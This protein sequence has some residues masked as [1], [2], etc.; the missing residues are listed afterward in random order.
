MK[1]T[2][3]TFYDYLKFELLVKNTNH[4]SYY[5]WGESFLETLLYTSE[6]RRAVIPKDEILWRSQLGKSESRKVHW[7]EGVYDDTSPLPHYAERMKPRFGMA[8][9]GRINPK[10]ISYLY[11]STDQ[12][13]AMAECRPW[14]QAPIS[15]GRFITTKELSIVDFS[16]DRYTPVSI[17]DLGKEKY[18]KHFVE[19]V[20]WGQ[21][22]KAFTEPISN[23]DF[24]ADYT[25]T[26]VIAELFKNENFDGI[27]Y[28]SALGTGQN[29]ALFDLNSAELTHCYLYSTKEISYI[30]EPVEN[31][32]YATPLGE[33]L[34]NPRASKEFMERI[35]KITQ[36]SSPMENPDAKNDET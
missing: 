19:M 16:K 29:I 7:E 5:P 4:Y 22:N 14:L 24:K 35:K 3:K 21:V 31:I 8:P 30:F 32:T 6:S 2:F 12:E 33:H 17:M 25:P 26:Q 1:K 36:K 18:D 28:K 34:D 27:K 10:G 11:L 15:L 23:S 20:I 9:E 13:T